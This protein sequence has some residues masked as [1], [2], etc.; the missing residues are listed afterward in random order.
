MSASAQNAR[1]NETVLQEMLSDTHHSTFD[2][3]TAPR[4]S[5][6]RASIHSARRGEEKS[7]SAK[8]RLAGSKRSSTGSRSLL[9]AW[10]MMVATSR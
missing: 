1:M 7:E 9:L 5:L 3:H 2:I 10:L 6:T 4:K 8:V